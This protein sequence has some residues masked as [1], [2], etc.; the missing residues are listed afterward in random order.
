MSPFM[1]APPQAGAAPAPT[2]T[3]P[4]IEVHFERVLTTDGVGTAGFRWFFDC[5]GPSVDFNMG[6]ENLIRKNTADKVKQ[7]SMRGKPPVPEV[8]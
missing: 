2:L 3:V 8:S 5:Q 7:A 1:Q 6:V 4:Q